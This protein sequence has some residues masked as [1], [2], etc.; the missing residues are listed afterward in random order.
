MHPLLLHE[1]HSLNLEAHRKAR[2]GINVVAPVPLVAHRSTHF[3]SPG[4][5][6][7]QSQIFL[8]LHM[9]TKIDQIDI[10]VLACWNNEHV[11]HANVRE[12][13]LYLSAMSDWYS[14]TC[15]IPMLVPKTRELRMLSA[16]PHS[17]N[18]MIWKDRDVRAEA[19]GECSQ[20]LE[21][22]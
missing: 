14:C 6:A 9:V 3:L 16:T 15:T 11:L 18:H 13:G 17:Y 22:R 5:K 4:H 10:R 19:C 8:F 2:A 7:L 1:L 12:Y 21:W 20:V